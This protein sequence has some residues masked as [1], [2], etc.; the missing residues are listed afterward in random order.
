M[1]RPLQLHPDYV[2]PPVT[3]IEVSVERSAAE[4]LALRYRVD[5]AIADLRLP[6]GAPARADALWEHTCFEIFIRLAGGA[7]YEFNFAPSE[8][9]AA[10]QFSAHRRGMTNLA[11][12]SPRIE[13]VVSDACC[14]IRVALELGGLTELEPDAPWQLGLSAVIEE[15]NGRKSYWALAH[16]PGKADFHHEAGFVLQLPAIA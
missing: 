15:A 14:E 9:W 4:A 5:G 7:Y 16:P 2:C 12:Q 1:R 11:V 8:Q 10:Y 3:G 13:S 6:A